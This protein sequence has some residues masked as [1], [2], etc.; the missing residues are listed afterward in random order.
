MRI[1]LLTQWYEPEPGPAALPSALARGLA[2]RGHDVQVLTGYPN[3]PT[4]RVTEG[5]EVRRCEDHLVDGV[6][7]RRVALY[8]SHD[9]SSARRLLN[10][11]SFGASSLVNGLSTLR[12][13][14]ALWVNY[15]PVTVAPTMWAARHLHG[16]PLVTHVLD[17]WPDTVTA[18][19][20]GGGV[21]GSGVTRALDLWCRGMYAASAAVA[22][23]S[24]GVGRILQTRGVPA[25]RLHYVPMWADETVFRPGGR[26]M[27]AEL[28]LSEDQVVLLY[29]GA[30]GGA[31]GLETLIEACALV[32]DPRVV[33]VLA[34][35]G[36][37][38]EQLRRQAREADL[39]NVRF[40]GRVPQSSMT[41]LMATADATY[42]SLRDH[43]HSRVTMPSKCQASLAAGV[44][45]IA[46][47]AGDVAGVVEAS[48]GWAV[49]GDR[50]E[51]IADALDRLARLTEAERRRRALTARRYYTTEFSLDRGVDHVERL[52]VEAMRGTT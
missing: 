18:S 45:V 20:H 32:R 50:P 19:G 34:G 7:V 21:I 51:A 33:C 44:P 52:L 15:S 29:A 35:S 4:G 23:I 49:P 8:P 27:R 11:A 31:Q 47:A 22:Y 14:D 38:E 42:L 46:A 28:G 10:Y 36:T 6:Q 25:D 5:Y 48:G 40:I 30:M 16:V 2:G 9:G 41:D 17:L 39:R 26:S 24:P 37:N 13:L 43:P 12:G 1:G 3:Y